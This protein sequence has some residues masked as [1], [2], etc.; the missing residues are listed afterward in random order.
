MYA[1][2]VLTNLEA[3]IKYVEKH[4]TLPGKNDPYYRALIDTVN[5]LP[6]VHKFH[7]ESYDD[8]VSGMD[9][10]MQ[11]KKLFMEDYEYIKLPYKMCWFDYQYDRVDELRKGNFHVNQRAIMVTEFAENFI[12]MFVYNRMGVMDP[13]P[14]YD[15]QLSPASYLISIGSGFNKRPDIDE[16][17]KIL[18]VLKEIDGNFLPLPLMMDLDFEVI[19]QVQEDDT[20][21]F[22]FLEAYLKLLNCKNIE[23]V[24]VA[25]P[26][27]LNKKRKKRGKHPIFD[28]HVLRISAPSKQ[29]GSNKDQ[30]L[31]NNRIHFCRGHYKVYTKDAPLMGKHIGMYWWQPHVRGT[32]KKV[33][34]KSYIKEK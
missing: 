30:G 28:Y 14:M 23:K 17:A 29:V 24:K 16:I 1:H 33:L 10:R 9:K 22:M 3:Q 25:G 6:M 2:R 7:A 5:K 12:Q 4:T 19:M 18:P 21:D 27:K 34:L 15:W 26:E 11:G 32:E 13:D 8:I 20:S 31:W